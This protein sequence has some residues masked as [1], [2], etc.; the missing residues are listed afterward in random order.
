MAGN[1]Q[2][3]M[4]NIESS[5]YQ[6]YPQLSMSSSSASNEP[7]PTSNN[8]PAFIPVHQVIASN[9]ML[10]QKKKWKTLAQ[11]IVRESI[12]SVKVMAECTPKG[13]GGVTGKALPK[14]GMKCLKEEMFKLFLNV[15]GVLSSLSQHG[16]TASS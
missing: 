16:K 11:T 6:P 15:R 9:Q 3:P 10:I 7:P 5:S 14:E 8:T 13:G 2:Q 1:Y 12:F 4:N